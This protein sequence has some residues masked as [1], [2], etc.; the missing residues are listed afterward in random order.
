[1]YIDLQNYYISSNTPIIYIKKVYF[2]LFYCYFINISI[3]YLCVD[4][5]EILQKHLHFIFIV[6]RIFFLSII[7]FIF[8]FSSHYSCYTTGKTFWV[9]E[10]KIVTSTKHSKLKIL[11]SIKFWECFDELENMGYRYGYVR[12]LFL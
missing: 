5:K 4:W 7:S 8:F 12:N 10:V 6:K 9:S 2:I 11:R 3:Q 1:M